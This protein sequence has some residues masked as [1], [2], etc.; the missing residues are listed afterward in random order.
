MRYLSFSRNN[1]KNWVA[2]FEYLGNGQNSQSV[3][4]FFLQALTDIV[5]QKFQHGYFDN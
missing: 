3:R 4:F 2:F 5:R 1:Y